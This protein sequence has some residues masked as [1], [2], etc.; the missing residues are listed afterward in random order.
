MTSFS[1]RVYSNLFQKE[2]TLKRVTL[3][4]P[5]SLNQKIVR[6]FC[7]PALLSSLRLKSE[8]DDEVA[9]YPRED[10][11]NDSRRPALF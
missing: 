4:E 3:E 10:D 11:D 8:H 9:C 6:V 5:I 1:F 7:L 2:N